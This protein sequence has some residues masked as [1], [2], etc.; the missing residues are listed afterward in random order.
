MPTQSEHNF[1]IRRADWEFDETRVRALR[2]E[3]FVGEQG[4]SASLEWDGLDPQAAHVIAESEQG[5]PIGTA[6]LLPSGQI[7]RMAVLASWRRRGVGKGLLLTLL[8]LALE[9]GCQQPFLNAQ[10]SVLPFY[11]HLGFEPDG[12]VFDEAGI[13][14][15]RMSMRNIHQALATEINDRLLG[16]T[17]GVL[18]LDDDRGQARALAAL[19]TQ[20]TREL[21]ILTPDP[22][23]MLYDQPAL[24]E[25]IGRLA[26][27]RRGRQPVRL[28]LGD[29]EAC[30]RRGSRLIDLSRQLTS[31]IG[32]R[33]L[34]ED[35]AASRDHYLV[36]DDGGY[37]VRGDAPRFG[38]M[39]DFA[40]RRQVRQLR[41]DFE[42]RWAQ[43]NEH[44]GLRRLYV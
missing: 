9:Q 44:P 37:F 15:Q 38:A 21:I 27:D 4:I 16:Q 18:R 14:H 36:A 25:A 11:R 17:A 5:E 41:H 22:E 39:A 26:R 40:D 29:A 24:L 43:G 23:P 12:A 33:V 3:V 35:L 6:R 34:P 10:V 42:Q 20:A 28:L 2:L 1:R 30:V 7:G 32:I 13:A 8:R 19:A 31:A